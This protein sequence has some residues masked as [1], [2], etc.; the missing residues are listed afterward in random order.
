[1]L[2]YSQK[3]GWRIHL[4]FPQSPKIFGEDHHHHVREFGVSKQTNERLEAC[5]VTSDTCDIDLLSDSVS[6]NDQHARRQLMHRLLDLTVDVLCSCVSVD[7]LIEYVSQS[8]TEH[9]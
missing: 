1:M 9:N 8:C 7:R 6:G 4:A 5:G 3:K 2:W